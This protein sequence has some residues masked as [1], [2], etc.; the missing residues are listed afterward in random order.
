MNSCA[1]I[2]NMISVET[3]GWTRP[4]CL[5]T[6]E[7]ARIFPIQQGIIKSF[8]NSKLLELRENLKN[9]FNEK[10]RPFCYRCESLESTGQKSLRTTTK[11][12]SEKRELKFLQFKMSNKCQLTCAHCGPDRSS[13]WAKFLGIKPHI[14][15]SFSLTESFLRELVEVL[16]Q[17]EVIKFTGGEPFLDPNHWLILEHLKSFDRS[18]CRLEYITNGISQFKPE[19]WEGWKSVQ[20]S[21]S[22]DGHEESY[23]WFRRGASWKILLDSTENLSKFSKININFSVTPFTVQ[24][25]H[26]SKNFWRYEIIAN[27]V[28]YPAHA[29]LKNFPLSIIKSLENYE[30]IPY[31][32]FAQGNSIEFYKN[33]ALSWDSKWNTKGWAN[34]IFNWMN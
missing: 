27:P 2:E 30:Q 29:S 17:I 32:N 31:W 4:C 13:G 1:W 6:S 26:R 34:K 23:E 20:C 11:L 22:V 7:K 10:T 28:V 24:D 15:N 25:Y 9:G 8:N 19:L 14:K 12:L 33:W 18:H 16:P 5:E 3:D 21:I